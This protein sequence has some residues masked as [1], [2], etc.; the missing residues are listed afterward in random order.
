MSRNSSATLFSIAL[1]TALVPATLVG[2]ICNSP[3]VSG[4]T[5]TSTTG[6]LFSDT[7]GFGATNYFNNEVCTWYVNCPVGTVFVMTDFDFTGAVFGYDIFEIRANTSGS[8]L[9]SYMSDET[10]TNNEF[11]TSEQHVSIYWT[12]SASYNENG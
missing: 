8:T 4:S 3:N 1:L 12:T 11:P 7:D 6:Y 10:T 9:A 5:Y 2:A